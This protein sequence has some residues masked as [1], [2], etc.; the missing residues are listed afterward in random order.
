MTQGTA[1][2]IVGANS[3]ALPQI[4]SSSTDIA[5]ILSRSELMFFADMIEAAQL[6]PY[7]KNVSKEVQKFRVMAKIVAG[8]GH[9]FDP[10]SSQENLH[11]IQGR[12]VLSAR[13]M[14]VKLSRTG[15]FT[16]RIEKLDKEGCTLV[17][18][19]LNGTSNWEIIGRVS[20]N[21]T[22]AEKAGLLTSNKAMYDKWEEDMY[23]SNAMKRAVRRYAP[24]A[25]DTI[26]VIYRLSKESAQAAPSPMAEMPQLAAGEPSADS[27]KPAEYQEQNYQEAESFE[28]SDLAEI[29]EVTESTEMSRD[30][31]LFSIV[32]TGIDNL[33]NGITAKKFLTKHNVPEADL[34]KAS[35]AQLEAMQAELN[36]IANEKA[37]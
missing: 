36:Q 10:I 9:Q 4:Q 8:L 24:Q 7:D 17:V 16:T 34:T 22:H 15:R 23:Y 37:A 20:F 3:A 2:E 27:Y 6:I 29:E 12:T 30:V 13:G 14:A 31:N 18:L 21:R 1:L 32:Q 33:F 35:P 19:E 11:V 25:L 5:N 26:P 28:A